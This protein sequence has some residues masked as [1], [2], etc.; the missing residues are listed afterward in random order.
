[1]SEPL[2]ETALLLG[3]FRK[4]IAS[5]E[6]AVE[7]QTEKSEQGRAKIYRELDVI[8]TEQAEVNSEIRHVK[9]RLD[10]ADPVLSEMNK[11]RERFNGMVAMLLFQ[12]AILGGAVA[13]F[14]KWVAVKFGI[15]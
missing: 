10:K 15:N 13:L 8:K 12:G 9:E 5:L 4:A 3:E 14:W 6:R 11:W 2:H 1:M 7:Q